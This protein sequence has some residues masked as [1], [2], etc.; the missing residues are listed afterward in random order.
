MAGQASLFRKTIF[1]RLLSRD[2]KSARKRDR[3]DIQKDSARAGTRQNRDMWLLYYGGICAM[4]CNK[5]HD[6]NEGQARSRLRLN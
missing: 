1:A 4:T 5:D 3:Q 2:Y 6:G